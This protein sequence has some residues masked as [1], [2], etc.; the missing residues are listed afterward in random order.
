MNL[1]E[2]YTTQSR[3]DQDLTGKEIKKIK[4]SEDTFLLAE[5]ELTNINKLL[6]KK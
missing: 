4:L 3:I 5:I 1:K 2:E 6:H